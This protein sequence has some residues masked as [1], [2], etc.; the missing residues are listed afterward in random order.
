MVIVIISYFPHCCI[1][2]VNSCYYLV[3]ITLYY[4][5]I[6]HTAGWTRCQNNWS[7]RNA[8]SWRTSQQWWQGY[9]C[10][11]RVQSYLVSLLLLLQF[12]IFSLV[13]Y[14]F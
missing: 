11:Y 4:V 13:Q 14:W 7:G 1:V 3:F 6:C 9:E 8:C 10:T 5:C 12:C 2:Q